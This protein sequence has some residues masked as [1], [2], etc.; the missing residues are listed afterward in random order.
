MYKETE[1]M[2]WNVIQKVETFKINITVKLKREHVLQL[3]LNL[4]LSA[5]CY[6]ARRLYLS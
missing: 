5:I 6:T 4:K 2:F 1:I 3:N